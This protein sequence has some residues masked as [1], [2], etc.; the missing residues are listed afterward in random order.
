M[1]RIRFALLMLVM[2]V[3]LT[4]CGQGEQQEWELIL[5]ERNAA[6]LSDGTRLDLYRNEHFDRWW[7][8][9][10]E[11]GTR[12]LMV[13][14]TE[15]PETAAGEQRFDDLSA[16]AREGIICW[17]DA[18]E[19]PYDLNERLEFARDDWDACLEAAGGKAEKSRFSVHS[20][21]R[22]VMPFEAP[23]ER[24]GYRITT[25]MTAEETRFGNCTTHEINAYF[26]RDT[27][28][29]VPV[30]NFFK[31]N[32]EEAC[33]ALAQRLVEEYSI[34]RTAEELAAAMTAEHICLTDEELEI[35]FPVG[36][37]SGEIMNC[38]DT[39]EREQYADLL[40][41]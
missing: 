4:A 24:L 31:L 29:T 34:E 11:D 1:K 33:L 36:T 39:L 22:E 13:N 12:L 28:E 9:C 32:E 6:T 8:W 23:G 15:R 20:V 10:M 3:V 21:Y 27:G 40:A 26:D 38:V 16:A 37:L 41:D 35:T 19:R 18:L 5:V 14:E 25:T 2:L 7:F 17:F 30:W